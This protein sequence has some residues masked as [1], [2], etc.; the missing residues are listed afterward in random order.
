M[1]LRREVVKPLFNEVV[2]RGHHAGWSLWFKDPHDKKFQYVAVNA[3]AEYGDWKSDVPFS[4]I[5]KEVFP[6]KDLN[7]T[8]D[9][10][11][12]SRTQ[13]N[14]EYWELVDFA[15]PEQSE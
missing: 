3:Y 1:K 12:N 9:A 2:K 10:I 8:L 7:E 4:E 6:D 11:I 15:G 13:V 5:F 14:S